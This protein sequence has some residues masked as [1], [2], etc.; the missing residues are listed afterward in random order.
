MVIRYPSI[1]AYRLVQHA[2]DQ[3]LLRFNLHLGFKF[4]SSIAEDFR[5]LMGLES[6]VHTERAFNMC[7][8]HPE[9]VTW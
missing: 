5:P 7:S 2:K 8:T 1:Q 9:E 4:E 6:G 3:R